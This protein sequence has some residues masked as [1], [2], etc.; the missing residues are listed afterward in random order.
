MSSKEQFETVN[1]GLL[2][3]APAKINLSLLIAGKRPDG[4]HELETVMAKVDFY[5][6][7][8]IEPG[9]KAGI[10]FLCRGPYWAP[11]GKDNLVYQACEMLLDS[12]DR[13]DD[14][15]ITLT[16]NIPAGSGLASASSDAASTL[17][18]L[19]RYLSLALPNH[20]LAKLA[21]KLGSDVAFFL[22][23]P[24]AFCTGKGEKIKK[25]T[26]IFDFTALLILPDISVSTKKVYANYRHDPPMYEKL[27]KLIKSH[28]EKNRFDLASKMC[29]NMLGISCFNLHR[30]LA[31]LKASIETLGIGPLCLSGSG[32]AMFVIMDRKEEE[33]ARRDKCKLDERIGCTSM[34][35]SNNRW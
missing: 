26:K 21:E 32:S 30:E 20:R 4:F 6:Q 25:I 19:N 3:R 7:I 15:R 27:S 9:Q 22:D 14:I 31:D 33:R 35:V 11:D 10:E 2:V 8:L 34:I 1:D 17:I 28:I 29:A 13:N 23:G 12:S 5:D 16:K 18:G 24:L